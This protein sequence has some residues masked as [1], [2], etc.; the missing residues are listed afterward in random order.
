M[1]DRS[2]YWD[3]DRLTSAFRERAAL[4]AGPPDLALAVLERVRPARTGHAARLPRRSVAILASSAVVIALLVGVFVLTRPAN[5]VASPTTAFG[6]PILSVE[7]A[8]GIQAQPNDD[9]EIA[10]RGWFSAAPAAPCPAP[11]DQSV[12]PVRLDC[13]RTMQWLMEDPEQLGV[14]PPTSAAIHPIFPFLDQSLLPT[15][16]IDVVDLVVM[17]HFDDRRAVMC[18]V[19]DQFGCRDAF[20]VDRLV[21]VDGQAVPTS[22]VLDLQ[23]LEP[24][25]RVLPR[26]SASDVDALVA[27]AAPRA[28]IVSRLAIPGQRIFEVEP[29]L[30]TGAHGIVGRQLIWVVNALESGPT[31][32]VVVRTFVLVEDDRGEAHEA[33]EAVPW[34]Q[35]VTGFAAINLR[36]PQESPAATEPPVTPS[37]NPTLSA[38][39]DF[40]TSWLGL[41]VVG[42]SDVISRQTPDLIDDTAMFVRGWYVAPDPTDQCPALQDDRGPIE[43]PCPAGQH[44]LLEQP[45][46][47]WT[48]PGGPW[49]DRR[50]AGPAL[51]PIVLPDVPFDVPNLWFDT[52]PS[53]LPVVLLGHLGDTRSGYYPGVAQFVV[54]ALVWRAGD[55]ASARPWLTEPSVEDVTS[56]MARVDREAGPAVGTWLSVVSG[57]ELAV[58]HTDA[59]PDLR[60]APAV[61]IARSLLVE[62]GRPRVH[63]ILTAD[64][65]RRVWSGMT[66]LTTIDLQIGDDVTLEISDGPDEIVAARAGLPEGAAEWVTGD[67]P[68]ETGKVMLG[69]IPERPNELRIAWIGGDC[70]RTWRLGWSG[71]EVL[72]WPRERL[73]ECR[74][75]TR[76][77]VVLTFDHAVELET[78]RVSN[79]GAG[80]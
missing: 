46:R 52:G 22:T 40:P 30:G 3:D 63:A 31:Q 7:E 47:L 79:G 11:I 26:W 72:L 29:S 36:P 39:A 45:E 34:S 8:I 18:G 49:I 55:A 74:L 53:P 35:S 17:G 27:M 59:P 68:P 38:T 67:G 6:R 50:P 19:D 75:W 64:K 42:V 70:D 57:A 51:N 14:R 62:D 4:R 76:W 2:R 73:G 80:G 10:V 1:T 9:R 66:L 65:G 44:W 21:S 20:I 25:G 60:D 56:V 16:P 78:I 48:D 32:A 61:W 43:Q 77:E 28:T 12:N 54:D 58:L 5:P 24:F 71:G 69:V 13:P 37:P 41:P 33:Y 23:R 15:D